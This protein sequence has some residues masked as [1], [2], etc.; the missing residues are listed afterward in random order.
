MTKLKR[1]LLRLERL[2]ELQRADGELPPKLGPAHRALISALA[3][4]AVDEIEREAEAKKPKS[5]DG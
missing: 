5:D 4:Q 2:R 1:K 3:E